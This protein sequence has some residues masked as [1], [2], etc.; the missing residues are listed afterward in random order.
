MVSICTILTYDTMVLLHAVFECSLATRRD[1]LLAY[2]NKLVLGYSVTLFRDMMEEYRQTID[3]FIKDENGRKVLTIPPTNNSFL[4]HSIH[5]YCESH[6][7]V[8]Q[9]SHCSK[10]PVPACLKCT[11]RLVVWDEWNWNWYCEDCRDKDGYNGAYTAQII[12]IT[13]DYKKIIITKK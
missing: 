1:S 7:H 8:S 10:K 9:F 12:E 2:I 4:R 3:R 5:E 6:D 13:T 11:S